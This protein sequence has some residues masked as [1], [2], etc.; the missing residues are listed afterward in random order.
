MKWRAAKDTQTTVVYKTEKYNVV[1]VAEWLVCRSG[2]G[3]IHT[4]SAASARAGGSGLE[5]RGT[6][7]LKNGRQD[8][9][10]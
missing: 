8:E 7:E 3:T 1:F 5:R 9:R 2:A 6:S 4:R 10:M